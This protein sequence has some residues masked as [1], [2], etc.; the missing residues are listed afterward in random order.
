MVSRPGS[1]L[2]IRL[3]MPSLLFLFLSLWLWL[4]RLLL[5]IRQ[6]VSVTLMNLTPFIP[7]VPFVSSSCLCS[8]RC[9]RSLSLHLS[10]CW[11]PHGHVTASFRWDDR[12]HT[13]RLQRRG[14]GPRGGGGRRRR[15][16]RGRQLYSE[17]VCVHAHA[18][19]SLLCH[20]FC[21]ENDR[22]SKKL[23]ATTNSTD[24]WTTHRLMSFAQR[25]IQFL[26]AED[27]RVLLK[28]TIISLFSQF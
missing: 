20:L 12:Y 15:R 14:Q 19:L 8:R 1:S 24:E 3:K 2:A 7:A 4:S 13:G 21:H 27:E 10:L 22:F 17:S 6:S 9:S 16:P 23:I 28:Q 5:L 18:P 25:T 26:G 11:H